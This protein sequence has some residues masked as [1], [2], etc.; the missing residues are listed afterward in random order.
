[1]SF[2]L[3]RHDADEGV[4]AEDLC[5]ELVLGVGWTIGWARDEKFSIGGRF[6][7]FYVWFEE[8]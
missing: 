1:M 6:Q 5:Q 4:G 3:E 2:G 7:G 8:F